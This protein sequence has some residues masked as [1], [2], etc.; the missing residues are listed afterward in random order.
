M[1]F[2]FFHVIEQHEADDRHWPI[3]GDFASLV[4]SDFFADHAWHIDPICECFGAFLGAEASEAVGSFVAIAP[5]L[6]CRVV[7]NN[8]QLVGKLRI[9]SED[10]AIENL[11]HK[12]L[13]F[14]SADFGRL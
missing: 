10:R 12:P 14:V 11:V 4:K 2:G 1:D 9:E 13:S 3:F 5:V 7:P 6:A 8:V